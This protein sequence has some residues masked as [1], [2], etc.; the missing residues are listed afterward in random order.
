[1]SSVEGVFDAIM[2]KRYVKPLYLVEALPNDPNVVVEDAS[3]QVRLFLT[4]ED[5][6]DEERS[7]VFSGLIEVLGNFAL[8]NP[9]LNVRVDWLDEHKLPQPM[10]VTPTEAIRRTA[11]RNIV[12]KLNT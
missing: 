1:M 6:T 4:Q 8:D 2:S 9:E 11:T 12:E 7:I 5:L 10:Y 3:E